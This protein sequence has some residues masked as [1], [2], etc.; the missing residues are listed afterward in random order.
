MKAIILAAGRGSR[1]QMLTAE[2][3]KALVPINGA[4]L[5]ERMIAALR[6]TEVSEIG[7]V[8]GYRGAMLE[9]FA[10]KSFQNVRWAQTGIMTS[11]KCADSWLNQEPCIISYSD[12]FYESSLVSDLIQ[13]PGDIVVGYDP[14]AVDLWRQRFDEPLADL[15]NFYISN[16]RVRVI[17]KRA[18]N[19]E[20][21]N[22]QYM[23]IFKIT[24]KGWRALNEQLNL[25]PPAIRDEIDMTSLLNALINVNFPIA[26]VATYAPWGEVDCPSDIGLYERIYPEL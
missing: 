1:L 19:L 7:I 15:E 5:L 16:G 6:R 4:T 12:I 8:V 2:C 11:L 9:G 14:A 23:G 25:L 22:G 21:L 24:P 10:D 18:K 20:R 3:P 17:G 26:G 13:H